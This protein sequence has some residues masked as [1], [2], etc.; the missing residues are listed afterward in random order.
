MTEISFEFFPPKTDEQRAQLAA[1]A[2]ALKAK[3]PSY[4][5]VT[6]GAGGSTLSYTPDTVRQLRETHGLDAAPHISCMG[7][8][9][10]E[11]RSL[12]KQYRDMGC[13]RLV[14]LR[15]DLPSGMAS[16][17][18]FRYAN[19]LVE[20]IRRETGDWFRIEVACY[21]EFHPQ[22]ED[23]QADLQNFRRKVAAGANGAITQY[24]FNPDAYFR[25]VD[26]VRGA[27]LSIPIVPGIMPITNF[28]QLKRFSDACGAEIPRW[29]AR[30]MVAYGDDADSIREFGADVVG[31]LCRKLIAGGVEG[32][33][34]Y[35]LNRARATLAVLERL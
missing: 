13:K 21:P 20:F 31:S 23:A 33:H 8:T 6:F 17:G 12:L 4:V 18:D 5:S 2:K 30:R 27:G 10:A 1:T 29:I 28:A 16:S 25:F 11:I 7:G 14:A 9:R 34:L 24:F 19:E 35:T 3:K 22:A 26:D 15:G 32:L